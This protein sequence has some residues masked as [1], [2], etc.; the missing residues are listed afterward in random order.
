VCANRIP[1][2]RGLGS[3]A[4]AI[5]AG[6]TAARALVLGGEELLDDA[7]ALALA[8]SLEGHGDNVAACLLGGLTVAWDEQ[9][10]ARAVRLEPVGLTPAAFVP[11]TRSSTA[12]ARKALPAVVPLVDA[13]ANAGRA[14]LLMAAATGRSDLLFAATEDR[15]HQDA[16]TAVMPR[17]AA[18][19]A[20]LR[21]DGIPAVLSGSGPTVLVLAGGAADLASYAGKT[22]E[23]R[24]LDVDAAGAAVLP[25]HG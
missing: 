1:Q 19:L 21:A 14:A 4:A 22:W 11:A 25:I 5:V 18:L 16:R 3:S 15:L 12:R 9:G 2:A 13:A 20:K 24:H 6:I 10:S 17:T 7:A 8:A 23:L